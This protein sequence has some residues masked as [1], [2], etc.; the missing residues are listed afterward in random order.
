MKIL[1]FFIAS[2]FIAGLLSYTSSPSVSSTD[3]QPEKI[4]K[5]YPEDI[6]EIS[7]LEAATREFASLHPDPLYADFQAGKGSPISFSTPDG[8]NGTGYEIKNDKKT[9][10]YLLVIHEWYGLNDY[11]K[12]GS[13]FVEQ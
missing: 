10:N 4:I 6:R 1:L 8:I 12:R 3:E 5:C 13:R 2:F 9:K 7:K 11:I